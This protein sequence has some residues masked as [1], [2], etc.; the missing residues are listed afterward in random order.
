V[1]PCPRT[2]Q[3]LECCCVRAGCSEI[4]DQGW[5]M[6]VEALRSNTAL[7]SLTFALVQDLY[8]EGCKVLGEILKTHQTLQ[9]VYLSGTLERGIGSGRSLASKE[10]CNALAEGLKSNR[11]VKSISLPCNS[12]SDE[13]YKLLAENLKANQALTSID[14]SG[15]SFEDFIWEALAESLKTHQALKSIDLSNCDRINDEGCKALAEI[16]KTNQVLASINLSGA[17]VASRGYKALAEGVQ[18]NQ[19]LTSLDLSGN[20]VKGDGIETLIEMVQ[21]NTSLFNL[22]S[23][24]KAVH[25]YY[26]RYALAPCAVLVHA[27]LVIALSTSC[28]LSRLATP[29]GRRGL[30]RSVGGKAL[31]GVRQPGRSEAA[32]EQSA[33]HRDDPHAAFK[34]NLPGRG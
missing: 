23:G 7:E 31:Q 20:K 29:Q 12:I 24:T 5:K 13:G 15:C 19:T 25:L 1:T 27:D 17:R 18:G 26:P 16:L 21:G 32:E 22:G 8:D 28:L 33:A 6:L 4:S 3:R 34:R 30:H 10:G 14:F 9:H 2:L 11:V